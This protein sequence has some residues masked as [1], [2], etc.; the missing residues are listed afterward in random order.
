MRRALLLATLAATVTVLLV[1]PSASGVVHE[2]YAQWCA[3]RG[4][5]VPPG[6]GE[7]G[8]KNFAQPVFATLFQGIVPFDPPGDQPAGFLLVLDYDA[9]P[10]KV[11]GIGAYFPIGEIEGQPLYLEAFELDHVAFDHC[12]K[13]RP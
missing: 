7:E 1:P 2:I 9:P 6:L 12:S 4:E 3:D 5:Q 10:S 11:S 8:R 13:L